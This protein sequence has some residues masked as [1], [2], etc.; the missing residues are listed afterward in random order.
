MTHNEGG[1]FYMAQ[2]NRIPG[3]FEIFKQKEG[4]ADQFVIAL[5][6]QRDVKNFLVYRAEQERKYGLKIRENDGGGFTGYTRKR[7]GA[8]KKLAMVPMVHYW[9]ET[10]MN[11]EPD[12]DEAILVQIA[13]AM[14]MGGLEGRARRE[15]VA[16]GIEFEG[17]AE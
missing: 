14:I 13:E 3:S 9:F 16:A 6:S 10:V 2:R 5:H 7:G 8:G 1:H 15:A 11:D 12:I 4:M 17:G